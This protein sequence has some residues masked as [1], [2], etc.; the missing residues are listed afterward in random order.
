MKYS[1]NN[2]VTSRYEWYDFPFAFLLFLWFLNSSHWIVVC[3]ISL[4]ICVFLCPLRLSL[5]WIIFL[6]PHFHFIYY[7]LNVYIWL[8]N[9][10]IFLLFISQFYALAFRVCLRDSRCLSFLLFFSF[11]SLFCL[12]FCF[13]FLAYRRW[14]CLD[15]LTNILFVLTEG[16]V[17][18]ANITHYAVA[19]LFY[20]ECINNDLFSIDISSF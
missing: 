14:L 12:L 16:G 18:R 9:I 5:S 1:S 2:T 19:C 3:P 8:L 17:A 6:F 15:K 10:L 7:H 11:L 20:R 13:L 4:F